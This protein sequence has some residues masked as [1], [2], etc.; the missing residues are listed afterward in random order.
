MV[1]Y[2]SL[3]SVVPVIWYVNNEREK[4]KSIKEQLTTK[5][6]VISFDQALSDVSFS[7]CVFF[8]HIIVMIQFLVF[9]DYRLWRILSFFGILLHSFVAII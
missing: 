2:I 7:W 9:V 1:I 5:I 3:P 4:K 6:F 8:F